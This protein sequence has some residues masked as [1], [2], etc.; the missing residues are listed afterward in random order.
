MIAVYHELIKFV[1]HSRS[2]SNMVNG[3][4]TVLAVEAW[5]LGLFLYLC[6]LKNLIHM[7][8]FHSV[9]L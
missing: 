4:S 6:E 3:N 5:E 1:A 7:D 8:H 9:F 2:T